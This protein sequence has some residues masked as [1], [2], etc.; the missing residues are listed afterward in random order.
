MPARWSGFASP[1]GFRG[2]GRSTACARAS[3]PR[4]SAIILISPDPT[5]RSSPCRRRC[6]PANSP[7]SPA[8]PTPSG[9]SRRA[10]P[11]A[12]WRPTPWCSI[13][14]S[15]SI[16]RNGCGS[17]PAYAP[18]TMPSRICARS[19]H[20]LRL[21]APGSRRS[22]EAPDD[23]AARRDCLVG[24]WLS[25][26]GSQ[27]GVDKGASHGIGH[28]LGGSAGV[29]HGYTSCVMLPHVLRF[30]GPVNAERQGMVAEALG[31][32]G[33]EAAAVI[34]ELIQSLGLPRMLRD[35]GVRRDQLDE[36][37]R[38]AMHDRWIHTNPRRIDGPATVRMLLEQAW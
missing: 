30:N 34:A 4:A 21:R 5:G 29:P 20:A 37:A 22:K 38:L 15:P 36:I 12:R 13:P 18:P 11:T 2:R 27:W 6:R 1:T 31:R 23:L 35:V 16:R 25:I 8:A 17:R 26:V 33:D 10:S 7:P 28:V 24:A 19:L 14:R 9:I 3:R 32:P